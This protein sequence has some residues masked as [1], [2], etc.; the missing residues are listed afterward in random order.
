MALTRNGRSIFQNPG[1]F[2]GSIKNQ[3]GNWI[4]GGLRNRFVGGVSNIFGA[5]P[6]GHLAPSAFILPQSSGAISS[7]T[8]SSSSITPNVSLIPAYNLIASGTLELTLTNAQLDQIVSAVVSGSLSISVSNA[9]L[10]AAAGAVASGS[11]TITVSDALAGA[12]FSVTAGSTMAIS[13]DSDITAIGHMDAEAGGATPL[14]PEGL[15]AAVLSSE[16]EVGYSLEQALKLILSAVAGKV[17]G[18]DTTTITIK[19]ILDNKNRIVATVDSNG[20]R[21]SLTYDVSD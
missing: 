6:S 4:K 17:S 7:T 10:A 16:I 2:A 19:N 8:L 14:S 13:P 1:S 9:L 20:N 11:M 12:I 21:T 18:A 15:A 5:W 3:K